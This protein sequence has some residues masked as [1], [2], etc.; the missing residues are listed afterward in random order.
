MSAGKTESSGPQKTN[1]QTTATE[2]KLQ[3]GLADE[4]R[5]SRR[6]S[7]RLRACEGTFPTQSPFSV[8]RLAPTL[9]LIYDAL[10]AISTV[11]GVQLCFPAH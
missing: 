5:Q 9:A 10:T 8:S 7:L 4:W 11:G 2:T 1:K 6:R 3:I